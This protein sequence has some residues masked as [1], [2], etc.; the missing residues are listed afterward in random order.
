MIPLSNS[1]GRSWPALATSRF[2]RGARRRIDLVRLGAGAA[3]VSALALLQPSVSAGAEPIQLKIVGGLSGVSQF[4]K[5]E[6]PFWLSMSAEFL[7]PGAA[8]EDIMRRGAA[9]GQYPQA[10]GRIDEFVAEVLTWHRACKGSQERLLPDGRWLLITER[11]MSEGLVVG[12]RTEITA[13]KEALGELAAANKALTDRDRALEFIAHHDDLTKIPNRALFRK[14]L[15]EMLGGLASSEPGLALL[16][17]DLDRFKDVNDTLGHPVGDVILQE[18]ARRLLA[19]AGSRQPVFRLGGDEFAVICLSTRLPADA[20]SLSQRLIE[21]LSRP[22]LVDGRR[23]DIGASVGVAV[24]YEPDADS[25]LKNA[26]LALYNAKSLGRSTHC[27]FDPE[28]AIRLETRI[29]MENDLRL[30]LS[31]AELEIAY[32][33]IYDLSTDRTCGLEALMRWRHPSRGIIGPGEFIPLAE[34]TGLIREIGAWVLRRACQDVASLPHGLKVAVNM[35]PLQLTADNLVATVVDAL[36]GAGLKPTRLEL[37]IT[38]TALVGSEGGTIANLHA[39]SALGIGIALDD[40]GTGYSSLS[41]LRS[42]PL[43]KIK[44]DQSFVREMVT[45]ADSLAIVRSVT[46]LAAELGM[47]TTA[48]G[49]ETSEQLERVREA[50]CTQA[51]GYLLGRP[52]PLLG[53][54]AFLD[55]RVP[56]VRSREVA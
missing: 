5:L 43:R 48:E 2:W 30:A 21:A 6:R 37:E 15:E 36:S 11:R 13:L 17:L 35:S 9:I 49:I 1:V 42:F 38:E 54:V 20:E 28:L 18:V 14:R 56:H 22:Y 26:D 16:Y 12:I 53:A 39:L 45:R 32:Q 10:E 47:D 8:F 46:Q 25:L 27:L 23:V 55:R 34:Q 41:H 51:Q 50:G 33:P 31:R 29:A 19:E 52:Q 4:T 24:A 44:I 40:F 3:V 7:Q